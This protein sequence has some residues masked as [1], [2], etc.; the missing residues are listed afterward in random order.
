METSVIGNR[1]LGD[2]YWYAHSAYCLLVSKMKMP[3][4]VKEHTGIQNFKK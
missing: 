1:E 2:N 3:D 4:S